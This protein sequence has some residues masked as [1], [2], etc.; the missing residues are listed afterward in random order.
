MIKRTLFFGN[1]AYLSLKNA[2]LV[3]R[4]NDAQTQEEVTKTVPIEDIGV[5]VLE[6]RQITITNGAMDALLQ[7]NSL[8]LSSLPDLTFF[9]N[10]GGEKGSL[11]VKMKVTSENREKSAE[12]KKGIE[13]EKQ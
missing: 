4:L 10:E 7:N 1:P 12:R 6:D 5:V 8:H 9:L 11:H 3:I 2:Q 13:R